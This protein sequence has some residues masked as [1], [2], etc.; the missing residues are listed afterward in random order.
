MFSGAFRAAFN[1]DQLLFKRH[2][3]SSHLKVTSRIKRIL[4]LEE[5]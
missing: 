5:S 4:E 1:V 2:S 3:R